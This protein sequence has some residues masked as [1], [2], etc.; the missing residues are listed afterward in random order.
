MRY[1]LT[2][3]QP[4]CDSLASCCHL[5]EEIQHISIVLSGVKGEY[6]N[7]IVVIHASKNP[8]YIAYVSSVLLDVESRQ[9]DMLFDANITTN[10]VV[11]H[12]SITKQNESG[13]DTHTSSHTVSQ[14]HQNN[15]MS[16]F[17]RIFPT[18]ATPIPNQSHNFNPGRRQH[19]SRL[20]GNNRPNVIFVESLDI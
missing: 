10:I 16:T 19:R 7:V 5:I 18:P 17:D 15:D 9:S 8:Y 20:Y 1:Y 4:A 11:N 12:S 3:I 14:N 2:T 13:Y 6:Y